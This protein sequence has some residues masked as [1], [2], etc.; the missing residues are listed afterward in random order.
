MSQQELDARE[1][2]CPMPIIKIATSMKGLMIGDTLKVLA[3]DPVFR[4]DVEAWCRTTGN[5]LVDYQ[6]SENE[7]TAVIK[8]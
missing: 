1:L 3:N 2:K 5:E 4:A 6:E 8:R 7:S